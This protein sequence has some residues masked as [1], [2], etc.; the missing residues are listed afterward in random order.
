VAPG[1][2]GPAVATKTSLNGKALLAQAADGLATNTAYDILLTVTDKSGMSGTARQPLSVLNCAPTAIMAI[3]PSAAI[4]CNGAVTL[5][6]SKSSD[7]DGTVVATSYTWKLAY[8]NQTISKTGVT[9]SVNQATDKLV[10]GATYAV[11]LTVKDDKGSTSPAATGT[12]TVAAGCVAV[13][14]PPVCA[15]GIPSV[16]RISTLVS[17]GVRENE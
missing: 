9:A 4:A 12:L 16:T 1:T 8:G 2:T 7:S 13:N 10:P 17:E 6:G 3:N 5:D 11:S 14:N 15:N